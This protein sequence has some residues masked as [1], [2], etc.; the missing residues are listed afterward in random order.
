M[1]IFVLIA[2]L[3]VA[4]PSYAR[5]KAHGERD[6]ARFL[7]SSYAAAN[8]V[9]S[10]IAHGVIRVESGYRCDARNRHSS[11]AGAG[12]LVRAT[13]R[14]LG[15]RNVFDCRENIAAAMRYLA[16]AIR[17]GGAGCAGVSL[18]NLGTNARPRCTAYGR[19]VLASA[20]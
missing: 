4:S 9:P 15:V 7:V 8:G 20:E 19:K 12:Q 17:K 3:A 13:A 5:D 10:R 6:S 11:A 14:A 18:Y 16:Q 1:K 2:A